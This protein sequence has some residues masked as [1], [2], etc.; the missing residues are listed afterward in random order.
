MTGADSGIRQSIATEFAR[1]GADVVITYHTDVEGVER[2]RQAVEDLGRRATVIQ[3]D[4]RDPEDV[5]GLFER[6]ERELGVPDILVN[7]AGI[8]G[9]GEVETLDLESWDNTLRTNLYGPFYCSRHFIR[10]RRQAGGRG[11][12]INVT[13]V[14]EEIPSEGAGA[15][16]AAKGGLRNL[17]RTLALELA[18][19]RINVVNIAPG[20]ILTP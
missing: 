6:V 9:E 19:D 16:D 12:L 17:I 8:S 3:L 14:H 7:N 15:Y 10:L 11:K 1:E 5:G 18:P 4:V 20:M 2:T 13:S